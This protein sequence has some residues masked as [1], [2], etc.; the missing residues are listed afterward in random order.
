MYVEDFVTKKIHDENGKL[1]DAK[2]YLYFSLGKEENKKKYM[3]YSFEDIDE[4]DLIT[5]LVSEVVQDEEG[6]L[7]FK[8]VKNEKDWETIKKIMRKIIKE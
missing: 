2:I 4:N 5:L 6:H 1:R 8:D 3:I 7:L